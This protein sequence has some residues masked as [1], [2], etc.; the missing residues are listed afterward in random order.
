MITSPNQINTHKHTSLE[1]HNYNEMSDARKPY[2]FKRQIFSDSECDLLWS[3]W[4]EDE[5]F[6]EDD[7][8]PDSPWY[9]YFREL[10]SRKHMFLEGNFDSAPPKKGILTEIPYDLL[11]LEKRIHYYV[12]QANKECFYLDISFGLM[13]K[14]LMYSG[15]GDWFHPHEDTNHWDNHHYDRKLTIIIQLS[16]G[17]DYEGGYTTVGEPGEFEQPK[18]Q[19]ERGSIF[20]F[21]TFL[22]H[23]VSKITSGERK[24]FICWYIGPKF[25]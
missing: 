8:T 22:T 11:W 13:S 14:Q 5:C 21:P 20:I 19:K 23:A 2:F 25:R 16:D 1:E 18:H 12:E 3:Y 4:N 9:K 17:E 10:R 24:A 6:V 15:V 7:V